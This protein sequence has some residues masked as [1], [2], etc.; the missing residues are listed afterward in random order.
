MSNH[1]IVFICIFFMT[2]LLFIG[3]HHSPEEKVYNYLEEGAQVETT[4][5]EESASFIALEKEEVE[6]YEQM[7][8]LPVEEMEKITTLVEEAISL[9]E[10]R[11][12]LLEQEKQIM[13]EAFEQYET[14]KDAMDELQTVEES[15][16]LEMKRWIKERENAY[17]SLHDRYVEGIEK[18]IQLYE[19]MTNEELTMEELKEQVQAIN[20]IYEQVEEDQQTFNDATKAFNEVKTELYEELGFQVKMKETKDTETHEEK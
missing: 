7:V 20:D 17:F 6:I 12:Q 16:V 8:T 10:E 14:A 3:C 4:F 9:A 13:K 2:S 11:T 19:S 1:R 18:D 5:Q 15:I